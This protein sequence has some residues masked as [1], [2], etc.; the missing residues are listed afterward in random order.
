MLLVVCGLFWKPHIRMC[1]LLQSVIGTVLV[2]LFFVV[3]TKGSG[4]TAKGT[5]YEM[6]YTDDWGNVHVRY[7]DRPDIISKFFEKSNMIDKHNQVRQSELGLEKCWL[8]QNPYFCLHTTI[9]GFNVVD[10]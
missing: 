4:T 3:A 5:P 7:V 8:T 10:S 1:H 2:Q 9:L 6:K